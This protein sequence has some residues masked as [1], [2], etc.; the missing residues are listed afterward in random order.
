[1]DP[2]YFRENAA[3]C[4]RLADGLS[5]N[6]PARVQLLELAHDFNRRAQELEAANTRRDETGGFAGYPLIP[7][8]KAKWQGKS[9]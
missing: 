2:R 6:N 7:E 3:R 9:R 5:L 4:L 1:M 8:M